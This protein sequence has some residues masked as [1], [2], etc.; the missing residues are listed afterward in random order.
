MLGDFLEHNIFVLSKCI[1][2]QSLEDSSQHWC[3]G[4]LALAAEGGWFVASTNFH[5]VN[6]PTTAF[7]AINVMELNAELG[8]ATHNQLSGA[9]R[10]GQSTTASKPYGL[11][12]DL[13]P[14]SR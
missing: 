9:G 11:R 7:Q 2:Y 8:I 10:Q 4:K 12:Y 1:G 13:V 3:A 6:T 14:V 5:G